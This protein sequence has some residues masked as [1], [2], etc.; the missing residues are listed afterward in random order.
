[1]EQTAGPFFIRK[2]LAGVSDLLFPPFCP[3]CGRRL[4]PAGRGPCPL[5]LQDI[6]LVGSPLCTVCGREMADSTVGD[7][8]CGR[9]L[10]RSPLYSSA[11]SVAHYQDPVSSLL[12]RL[13]Y[14]GD[15]S[16]LPALREIIRL[17]GP[18]MLRER[19][20]VIPVPLH[21]TRLRRRG[22]NQAL[23]LA[24]LFFAERKDSILID[25]LIR[26]RHTT[27]QTGLD[28]KERRRNLHQAF[29]VRFPER[30]RGRMIVL[31][32]DVFTTGTTVSECSRT[33]LG[34]GAEDVRV[35]TLARVRE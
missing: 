9:C 33:L 14:Q 19:E 16:V 25:T 31:V 22:F 27:S 10:R 8:H 34:A 32:D 6:S 1:M 24:N 5:C 2:W 15:T 30:V 7:H 21:L 12:H 17:R 29:A 20:R 35:V 26:K 3:V 18:W 23:I 13:K 28:G 11:R 4:L